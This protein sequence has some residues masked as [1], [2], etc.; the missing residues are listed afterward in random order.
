M[1]RFTF[2]RVLVNSLLVSA[3]TLSLNLF[4]A[5]S[6]FAGDEKTTITLVSDLSKDARRARD[7]GLVILIEFS[8]DSCEYCRLLEDEFLEPMNIDRDYSEKIIIRSVPLDGA[9]QFRGFQGESISASQFASKYDIEVTPT[10]VFLD[11]NGEQLSEKLVGIWS[12][13]FFG[14]YIDERIDTARKK[15]H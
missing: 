14:G 11:A 6:I 4:P 13:D 1:S 9:H 12:L 15:V 7:Q 8:S 5:S 2:P 3:I 10:M